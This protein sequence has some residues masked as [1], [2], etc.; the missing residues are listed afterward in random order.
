MRPFFRHLLPLAALLSAGCELYPEDPIF[1]YGQVLRTDGTPVSGAT[2]S[3]ERA[4]SSWRGGVPTLNPPEF[5]PH[6]SA[7]TRAEGAFTL[8]LLAGATSER[9]MTGGY[10]DWRSYRFRIVSQ[11]EGRA[12]ILSF[13]LGGGDVE[14]PSLRP[15]AAD[16]SVGD[17]TEGHVAVSFAPVPLRPELPPTGTWRVST[18]LEPGEVWYDEATTPRP[19]V[20]LLQRGGAVLWQEE[21]AG[22]PWMAAPWLREDFDELE[23]MVRAQSSGEWQFEPLGGRVSSVGYRLEWRSERLP[24]PGVG[25]HPI[26]RGASCE[27]LPAGVTACPWTDGQLAS[28]KFSPVSSQSE[29]WPQ[30]LRLTLAAPARPSRIVVRGLAADYVNN[31]LKTLFVEGSEDGERWVSLGQVIRPSLGG[32][33]RGGYRDHLEV[34]WAADNPLDPALEVDLS[35]NLYLEGALH[36]E[37]AVRHVRL[38]GVPIES[39]RP[40][41]LKALKEVSLFE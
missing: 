15:W 9:V 7:T 23:V 19:V 29:R 11:E 5:S 20:Q 24:M 10:Y 14:L 35:T 30:E 2:L 13:E 36:T 17:G 3:F 12:A 39:S 26:S 1:A 31:P 22:S 6:A 21:A 41:E 4:L 38:R 27:P 28:V 32:T 37:V 25:L 40:V 34:L 16:L 8:E 18:A 33:D